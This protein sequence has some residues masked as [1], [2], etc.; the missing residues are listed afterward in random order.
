MANSYIQL[1]MQMVFAVKYR[2]SLANQYNRHKKQS[3]KEKYLALL[4][5]F[6]VDY[7]DSYFFDWLD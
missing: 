4:T 3:F 5:A 2:Q 6:Q 1:Y 7:D